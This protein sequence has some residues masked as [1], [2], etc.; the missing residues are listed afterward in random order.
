MISQIIFKFKRWIYIKK[1]AIVRKW[2]YFKF[3]YHLS[4]VVKSDHKLLATMWYFKWLQVSR[5]EVS[6]PL[7]DDELLKRVALLIGTHKAVLRPYIINLYSTERARQLY[8]LVSLI[9]KEKFPE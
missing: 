1:V 6:L 4:E 7:T 2:N 8:R 3:I 9:Q 5:S